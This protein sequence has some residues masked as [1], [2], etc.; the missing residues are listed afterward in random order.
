MLFGLGAHFAV[1]FNNIVPNN[2]IIFNNSRP[3]VVLGNKQELMKLGYRNKHQT[4]SDLFL[5]LE[6][7]H[8]RFNKNPRKNLNNKYF[9]NTDL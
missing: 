2:I 5:F 3:V 7:L 8:S 1:I 9:I 4:I 6:L